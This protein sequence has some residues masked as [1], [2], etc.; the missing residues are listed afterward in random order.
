MG[1]RRTRLS[2]IANGSFDALQQNA[3][4]QIAIVGD[5]LLPVLFVGFVI[6][7]VIRKKKTAP[8]REK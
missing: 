6:Y 4:T 3:A 8:T 5:I 2:F 7:R 1:Q